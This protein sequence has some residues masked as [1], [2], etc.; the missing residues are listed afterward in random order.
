MHELQLIDKLF[1]GLCV[2]LAQCI[3]DRL[4]DMHILRNTDALL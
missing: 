4:S 3:A 1:A 2:A